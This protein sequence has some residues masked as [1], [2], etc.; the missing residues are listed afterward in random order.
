M[1][2]ETTADSTARFEE[3]KAGGKRGWL[4]SRWPRL[5]ISAAL[6]VLLLV[7]NTAQSGRGFLKVI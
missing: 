7:R 5:I 4:R 6:L 2:P 3:P 1:T